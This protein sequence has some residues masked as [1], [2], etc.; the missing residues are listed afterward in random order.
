MLKLFSFQT[1]QAHG[2]LKYID[3]VL[4]APKTFAHAQ[5]NESNQGKPGNDNSSQIS[6]NKDIPEE[7]KSQLFMV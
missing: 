2:M 5:S 3:E 1:D 6:A 7:Y 4:F